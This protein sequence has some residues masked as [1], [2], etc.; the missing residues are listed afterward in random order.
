MPALMY[1]SL[2]VSCLCR[3]HD[4][5]CCD[6]DQPVMMF[7]DHCVL[8]SGKGLKYPCTSFNVRELQMRSLQFLMMRIQAN[9]NLRPFLNSSL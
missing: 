1:S 4:V 5:V 3:L 6:R 2:P 8:G 9:L 7:M